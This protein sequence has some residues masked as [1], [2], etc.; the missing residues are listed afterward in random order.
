MAVQGVLGKCDEMI[1]SESDALILCS[2]AN[3]DAA[4]LR[5]ETAHFEEMG[6]SGTGFPYDP[7][8]MRTPG[9]AYAALVDEA[10]KR[11]ILKA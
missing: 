7:N 10:L 8:T 2:I 11:G 6:R 3:I 9:T 5:C 4:V 1:M